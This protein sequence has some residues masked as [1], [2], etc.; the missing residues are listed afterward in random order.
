MVFAKLDYRSDLFMPAIV[1]PRELADA[2]LASI[3]DI[4]EAYSI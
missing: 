2:Q 1:F 3:A 4:R